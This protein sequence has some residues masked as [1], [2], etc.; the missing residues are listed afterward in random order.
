MLLAGIGGLAASS[1]LLGTGNVLR[2]TPACA[3]IAAS[4][5]SE[6]AVYYNG[7]TLYTKD[8][9]HWASS[10]S[11]VSAC[12]FEPG[13]TEDLS[14]ALQILGATRTQFA[15]KSGGH[16]TNPGFSSTTGVQ[17]A[18]YLFSDITYDSASQT[19][20][21]GTGAIWDDVY[22]TLEA[23]GV[24]V[25]GGK[26]TGVGVGGV[27]LGG[28]FSYLTNQH[29][30]AIDN[31]VSYELILPNGT[32]TT[33][34]SSSNPDLYFGLRGGFNNFGIVTYFTLKTY[35]Q[36]QIWGGSLVYTEDQV[37]A[38]NAAVAN[39]TVN[40]LDPK[41]SIYSTYNYVNGS[42][43]LSSALFYDAPTPPDGMFDDFSAIPNI[44]ETLS[45]RTFASMVDVEPVNDTI[46]LRA[47][48]NS[49]AV[50]EWTVPLLDA[51]ANETLFY[52]SKLTN[53]SSLA[54]VTY[55]VRPYLE[56]IFSHSDIPSAYPVSRKR[57]YSYLEFFYAWVD[58]NDDD[59]FYGIVTTSSNYMTSL[60][61]AAGQNIENVV[62]YP[63]NADPST[64]LE[65]MYG[66]NLPRLRRIKKAVDPENVMGLCGG[67]KF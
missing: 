24:M 15:V 66:S 49:I 11:Q 13:T 20:K 55:N 26:V 14:K 28:G 42:S 58:P 32:V 50:E 12:T 17:I 5:S 48:F 59:L 16:A 52:G 57:G 64:S 30:L 18:M 36:S 41:A 60:A 53:T 45:T 54:Q 43:I 56:S 4:I 29:G 47:V 27:V 63:N 67:W 38:I 6:S 40:V 19:A 33:V 25:L 39:F 44:E 31:V 8:N 10:S 7:S 34:T 62:S 51:V 37:G 21:V 23:L 3:Q 65:K 1:D 61:V 22:L 2:D 35:P 46:G 9:Y